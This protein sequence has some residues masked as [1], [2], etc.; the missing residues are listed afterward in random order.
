[1]KLIKFRPQRG[2]LEE[3][4][5]EHVKFEGTRGALALLLIH[6]FGYPHEIKPEEIKLTH[7]GWDT[8]IGWDAYLVSIK[9]EAV[10]YTDNTLV[11]L[12]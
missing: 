1:M 5:R 3:S 10:G 8:R 7:V 2:G 4:M 11:E 9:G 6:W 12:S